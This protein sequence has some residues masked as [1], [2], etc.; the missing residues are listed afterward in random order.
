MIASTATVKSSRLHGAELG[1]PFGN[2][3]L[4]AHAKYLLTKP[5]ECPGS[6]ALEGARVNLN[7][8][9]GASD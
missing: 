9:Y 3:G 1:E 5:G 2:G 4:I 8:D 6:F 7:R